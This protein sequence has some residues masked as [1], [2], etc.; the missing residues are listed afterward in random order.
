M[1]FYTSSL[2]THLLDPIYNNSKFQTEFRLN[3]DTVYLSNMRICNLGLVSS[4]NSNLNVLCGNYG[5]VKSIQLYDGN[6][7]LD[8]LL[9]ANT[10]LSFTQ[11]NKNNEQNCNMDTFTAKNSLG[12]ELN[13]GKS[14]N[15]YNT[16]GSTNNNSTTSTSW[17]SLQQVFPFLKASAYVPTNLF[18]NLRIVINYETDTS[19]VLQ[20]TTATMDS[21]LQ[22]LLIVDELVNDSSK[23]S[24]MKSYSP[25]QWNSIE[26]DRLVL[27]EITADGTQSKS[28]TINGFDN[29]T[30][31]RLLIV[32]SPTNNTDDPS[33]LY[34]TN[35]SKVNYN[36]KIQI[37]INGANV[38][39]RDGIKNINHRLALL[40]DAWGTCNSITNL[41][42]VVSNDANAL[43]EKTRLGNTDYFGCRVNQFIQEFQIDYS[44]DKTGNMAKDK[45]YFQQL[46][47]NIFAEVPKA[48][49]VS[50]GQYNVVYL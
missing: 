7:L 19:K 22:P 9:E 41:P 33:T 11:Y 16:K 4:G 35:G 21:T 44:R 49:N 25:P 38:F 2:K 3:Q 45:R 30:I 47:L 8:Q 48:I 17:L 28:F 14:I 24:V 40:T 27:D 12:F 23:A 50:E 36:Q 39:A 37:R 31:N 10:W 34:G 43:V 46:F 29:K 32:N 26:H 13:N 18:K 6:Q 42:G 1:S 5:I 20:S 15:C